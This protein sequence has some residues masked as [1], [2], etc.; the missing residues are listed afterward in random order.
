MNRE[1]GSCTKCCEG[2][3]AGEA[4]G[5]TFY[6]GKPCH[7]VAIGKNCTIYKDRP[8]NPC[9]TYECMWKK[10]DVLPVWMK[11][12]EINTIIDERTTD[13]GIYFINVVEAGSKIDSKVLTWLVEYS[14]QN[15]IN[16]FWEVDNGKHW[17]G[18]D[19]F[20]QEMSLKY[21]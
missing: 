7:F 12:S 2:F 14:L 5:K 3:L 13:N 15:N 20:C 16:I 6:K 4:L 10:T 18:S 11:P 19:D 8:I 9:Q 17:I 21:Q 1:C